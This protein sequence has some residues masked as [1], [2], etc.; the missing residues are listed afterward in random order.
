M[1][2]KV[3][4]G[5]VARKGHPFFAAAIGLVAVLA[6]A[7]L[8][9]T[10]APAA[11]ASGYR[12]AGIV[13]V[14]NDYL[15]FLELPGGEQVLV[16]QGSVVK[17]GG[18]ILLLDA[19]RMRI[20]LPSEVVELAL[21]D[22]GRPVAVP[23]SVAPADGVEPAPNQDLTLIRRVDPKR[24]GV[25][26]RGTP[27]AAEVRS[28]PA[29]E[30]A[31]RLAPILDLPP[32]SKVVAVNDQPVTSADAAIAGLA[33]SLAS[34]TAPTLTLADARGGPGTRVYLLPQPK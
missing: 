23:A 16:R 20:G 26:L 4:T 32:N 19:E 15:G 22:S 13:A 2:G 14:G 5:R 11:A 10:N 8:S 27:K 3:S 18:R 21:Q 24:L 30:T 1:T 9:F 6:L 29:T 33:Q 28:T 31:L 7:L 25:Q 34:N 12:L 17:G